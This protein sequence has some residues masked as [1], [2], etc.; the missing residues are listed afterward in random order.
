MELNELMKVSR[1]RDHSSKYYQQCIWNKSKQIYNFDL[2]PRARKQC[3][4]PSQIAD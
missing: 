2:C 1:W 4:R 3:Y